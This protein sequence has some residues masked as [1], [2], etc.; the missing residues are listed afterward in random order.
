MK[1]AELIQAKFGPDELNAARMGL[2]LGPD[3]LGPD[4]LK[5]K[6]IRA[7]SNFGYVAYEISACPARLQGLLSRKTN[8]NYRFLL[9]LGRPGWA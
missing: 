9:Q 1:I 8:E 3:G 5:N 4:G 2:N 7:A 6:N